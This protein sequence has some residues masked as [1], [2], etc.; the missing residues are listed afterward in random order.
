MRFSP[1]DRRRVCCF[2]AHFLCLFCL[3]A[4]NLS[5]AQSEV[6]I[7]EPTKEN[8][9]TSK[10]TV[11]SYFL[12]SGQTKIIQIDGLDPA[13]LD[14]E[15]VSLK[16]VPGTQNKYRIT[17][18]HNGTTQIVYFTTDG[19]MQHIR[20]SVDVPSVFSTNFLTPNIT[21]NKPVFSYLFSNSS[22]FSKDG[23]FKSPTYSHALNANLPRFLG[24]NLSGI[25]QANHDEALLF[26]IL[27]YR[28]SGF[29]QAFGNITTSLSGTSTVISGSE[30]MGS[31]TEI[32]WGGK[33]DNRIN[34][35][36][37]EL[38]KA[39]YSQIE[40]TVD[41]FGGS[42]SYAKYRDSAVLP[43]FL[44]LNS[45]GYRPDQGQDH[46]L[47]VGFDS[48]YNLSRTL[49]LESNVLKANGGF[50]GQLAQ[51]LNTEN[52]S[53]KL[54][55]SFVKA[56]LEGFNAAVEEFDRRD[57]SFD[58]QHLFKDQET[59]MTMAATYNK[60][61][62]TSPNLGLSDFT[63]TSASSSIVKQISDRHTY[64]A[65]YNFL[66]VNSNSIT[67]LS[68]GLGLN[69]V[70]IVDLS[71]YMSHRVSANYST[72]LGGGS[73]KNLQYGSSHSYV[74]EKAKFL[75]RSDLSWNSYTFDNSY[76]SLSLTQRLAFIIKKTFLLDFNVSYLRPVLVDNTN[77]IGLTQIFTASLTRNDFLSA[78]TGIGAVFADTQTYSGFMG[79]QYQ[80]FFGPGVENDSILKRAFKGTP[81]SNIY[82]QI[83]I[84]KNYNSYF[85][86][87]DEPLANVSVILDKQTKV[88]TNNQGVFL[89]PKIKPGQ[90]SLD[91]TLDPLAFDE[92]IDLVLGRN[93]TTESGKDLHLNVPVFFKKSK[94]QILFVEDVNADNIYNP[95]GDRIINMRHAYVTGAD[96]KTKTYAV[97]SQGGVEAKGLDA[98]KYK[99]AYDPFEIPQEF[100][101][102]SSIE[103]TV[104]LG[105]NENKTVVFL[106]QAI[107][108]VHGQ[109]IFDKD[110]QHLANTLKLQLNA[111]P[112]P[113][114][115]DSFLI[116]NPDAGRAEF[117]IPNLPNGFCV[118]PPVP[119]VIIVTEGA[120]ERSVD[121]TI[122]KQCQD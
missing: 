108:V 35:F 77:N 15:L 31:A 72:E 114:K 26:A 92:E 25:G 90:H 85:D 57:A 62:A 69:M 6:P 97:S 38:K 17:G 20:I 4:P 37:G 34:A 91:L 36:V 68:N 120:L 51:N 54:N 5:L 13:I 96:Q 9:E 83:Y 53:S 41:H 112:V 3:L 7:E 94:L 23:F 60:S 56:G 8:V 48:A 52:T 18:L 101:A 21:G 88:T 47:G 118:Q 10:S 122:K 110:T 59:F 22:S 29:E 50:A 12:F 58:L 106:F 75:A 44:Q 109:L 102:S 63:S 2:L 98:G 117:T 46:K 115:N 76:Q 32:N 28:K 73:E 66:S 82:G 19:S 84:D 14:E 107:R 1:R 64:S 87:N 81:K 79:L 27:N 40:Q 67:A 11:I 16:L 70:H 45:F 113:V 71:S 39:D 49:S 55:F 78:N 121:F 74:R 99:I 86:A 116:V 89:Y 24:G 104:S 30:L 42:Y 111:K 103:L 105:K 65:N 33:S 93:L 119:Y 43:D 100:E 95:L 61:D 80:K